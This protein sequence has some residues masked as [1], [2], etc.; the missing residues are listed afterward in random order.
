MNFVSSLP[1]RKEALD[2]LRKTGCSEHVINHCIVVA[3]LAVEIASSINPKNDLDLHLVEIGALLHDI[4]RSAA[5]GVEHGSMGAAIL[6]KLGY[7]SAV[8]NIV[9]KHVGAG[10]PQ[11]E[12]VALGL[13]PIDHIPTTIEEKV[14][15]YADK[16]I[17]GNIR[18][19]F[20]EALK[21]FADGL[22]PNHPA[23]ARFRHLHQEIM[24]LTGG[25][26]GGTGPTGKSTG[27]K[28]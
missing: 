15:C 25:M 5:H 16:L 4:G 12:A 3:K 8:I 9:R 27:R 14:V 18:V 20:E 24:K 10:I 22:G 2:T 19:S 7:P 11:A 17:S 1:T 28:R 6:E 13:P 23:V 21:T 26:D